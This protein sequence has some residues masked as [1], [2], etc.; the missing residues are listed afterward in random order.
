MAQKRGTLAKRIPSNQLILAF[1]QAAALMRSKRV[2]VMTAEMLLSAFLT[3]PSTE[4]YQLLQKFSRER[5]FDWDTLVYDINR[6]ATE[7]QARDITQR[8]C[9]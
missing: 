4:A 2:T 6:A 8:Y 7:R 5:G 1:N 9:G 3:V